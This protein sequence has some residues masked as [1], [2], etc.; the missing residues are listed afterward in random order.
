MTESTLVSAQ[1]AY[2]Y[3]RLAVLADV[4]GDHAFAAALRRRREGPA[5]R[6]ERS[7]AHV[8]GTRADTR[9]TRRIGT[10]AIF[11]E[12]QPWAM[13][14]GAPSRCQAQ[15]LVARIRRFLT[16][17]RRAGRRA[18]VRR[19]IGSAQSPAAADPGISE[20]NQLPPAASQRVPRCSPVAAGMRSTAG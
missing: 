18:R 13:L 16:G 1:A 17:D 15:T 8:A 12:Q 2:I 3:A 19:V 11:G 7:G 10:G 5:R 6:R 9:A 4:R 20:H 14:A